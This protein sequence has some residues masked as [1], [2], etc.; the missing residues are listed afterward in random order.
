MLA[1]TAPARAALGVDVA[2]AGTTGAQRQRAAH[3]A[4]ATI[5]EVYE[6]E[7]AATQRTYAGEGVRT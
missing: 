2:L 6:A 7:V 3:A 1:W 4:G 5:R